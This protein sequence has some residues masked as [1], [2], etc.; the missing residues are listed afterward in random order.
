MQSLRHLI[1]S[2]PLDQLE[3]NEYNSRISY[4]SQ[5]IHR[6]AKSIA[7]NGLLT[8][9]KVRTSTKNPG[10][11]EL[12]YGHRRYLAAKKLGLDSIRAE[13]AEMS[14]EEMILNSL[15]ENVEREDLSDYE[16]A[17]IF[18]RLN[19]EF[20]KTYD[21]IGRV[22][23]L[24]K[25]HVSSYIAMVR[26]F[27]TQTLAEDPELSMYLRKITE[28]H[29]RILSRV[30]DNRRA[31]LI[32]MIVEEGL[33]VRELARI[34]SRLRS[35]FSDQEEREVFGRHEPYSDDPDEKEIRKIVFQD[36]IPAQKTDFS[37]YEHVHLYG[38]GFDMFPS[39]PAVG[40]FEDKK[41]EDQEQRW[42]YEILPKLKTK[43]KNL[44]VR[45]LGSAA[46]ATF[47]ASY[48]GYYQ[49]KVFDRSVRC[50]MVLV[51]KGNSW[52]VLHEHWS[53]LEESPYARHQ[54]R[55]DRIRYLVNH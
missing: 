19:K 2:I 9:V 17:L 25:Q 26:L 36:M 16:K 7:S 5:S 46:L 49:N 53:R 22:V 48:S 4:T 20:G 3:F 52:K 44:K 18:E 15:V 10:K 39:Y 43:V 13:L 31:N 23:G 34:V 14:N 42:F 24:S 41:A 27:D 38:E 21:E 30:D 29:A 55:S 54:N 51:R 33:S 50:S 45:V 47:I 1:N 37:T 8:P 11:F 28:H 32:R 35:W 12:V 6:M 40:C